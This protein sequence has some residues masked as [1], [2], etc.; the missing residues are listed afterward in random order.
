MPV[1]IRPAIKRPARKV[2]K[3][4][5]KR[6][7]KK[8]LGE[9]KQQ[10]VV[11]LGKVPQTERCTNPHQE[12]TSLSLPEGTTRSLAKMGRAFCAPLWWSLN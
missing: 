3:K 6:P 5:C 11:Q 10:L 7:A 1:R 8:V 12:S 4:V 9:L 2:S